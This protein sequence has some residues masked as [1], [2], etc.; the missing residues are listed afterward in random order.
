M[1]T[2]TQ[3]LEQMIDE[4][5]ALCAKTNELNTLTRDLIAVETYLNKLSEAGKDTLSNTHKPFMACQAAV[6]YLLDQTNSTLD[7]RD[8]L[9]IAIAQVRQ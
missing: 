8:A 5:N 9:R 6:I 7:Q 1:E 3:D 2:R 4:H